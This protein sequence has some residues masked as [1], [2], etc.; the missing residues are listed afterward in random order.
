MA[1]RRRRQHSLGVTEAAVV[2]GKQNPNS[3]V[4]LKRNAGAPALNQLTR[5]HGYLD[6]AT[7]A[8][9]IREGDNPLAKFFANSK[10]VEAWSQ[11]VQP[12]DGGSS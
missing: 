9:E 2:A 6:P 5:K 12:I 1:K 10:A 11:P 3:P 7:R 4:K 8:R